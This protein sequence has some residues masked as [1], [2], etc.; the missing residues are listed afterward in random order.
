MKNQIKNFTYGQ[1]E[2]EVSKSGK[3]R[4]ELFAKNGNKMDFGT[5]RYSSFEALPNL[6]QQTKKEIINFLGC[7]I[8]LSDIESVYVNKEPI[9]FSDGKKEIYNRSKHDQTFFSIGVRLKDGG[10]KE[11]GGLIRCE[12]NKWLSEIG[13]QQM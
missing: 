13:M 10:G 3:L 6:R 9:S 5:K 8:S 11:V 4:P 1:A 7:H 2:F 12:V